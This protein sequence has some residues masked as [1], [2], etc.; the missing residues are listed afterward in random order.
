MK[1]IGA[2]LPRTATLSQ[3]IALELLGLA[4]CY[5]MVDVLGDLDRAADWRG[6]M[7]G[8]KSLTEIFG[9]YPATV[10]WPGSFF[11][12]DLIELYP[13]A[14]VLLSVRDENAW[15]RSMHDTIWGLFYDD[16]LIRHLSWARA[17]VDPQWK[18]YLEMMLEMWRRSGLLQG[19]DTSLEHMSGA[20]RRYNEE[21]QA[22]VPADRLLVWAPEDGWEPL[23]EFLELPVPDAP[24]PCVNDSKAFGE[25]I[26]DASLQAIERYRALEASQTE[27]DLSVAPRTRS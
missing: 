14:K 24:F 26:V 10:D 6:A 7:D 12:R 25:R 16:I 11:Y 22:T 18:D 19:E 2:G 27:D 3:K 9:G 23:C 5:H 8:K 21:V 4:P 15:A 1:L 13:E 20:F 17:A